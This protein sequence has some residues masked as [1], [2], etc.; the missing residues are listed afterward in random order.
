[1]I[2]LIIWLNVS[3]LVSIKLIMFYSF[4]DS[5]FKEKAPEFSVSK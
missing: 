2:K 1:M 4:L 3:L 5:L